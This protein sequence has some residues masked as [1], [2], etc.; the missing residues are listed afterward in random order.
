MEIKIESSWFEGTFSALSDK[1]VVISVVAYGHPKGIPARFCAG[2]I[3]AIDLAKKLSS[4]MVRT[5]IRL[6]DP[7]PIANHCNG[8]KDNDSRF[9]DIVSEFLSANNV[10]FT[11]DGAENVSQ[12]SLAILSELGAELDSASDPEILGLVQRIKESGR[13]HGG[14]MGAKNAVLYMAAHP[15]SWLDLY[16]PLIW[17]RKH[18]PEDTLFANLMSK[19]ESRF[20]IVR[21]FLQT[22]RPDLCSGIDPIE[23]YMTVCNTPCY[24]P[25]DEEPTVDDLTSHGYEWC[26]QRYKALK[27]ASGNHRRAV[28]DFAAIMSFT[29]RV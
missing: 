25:L 8:W 20:T 26:H 13:K 18:V 10:E 22:R 12:D 14:D 16:H 29:G 19:P 11:F 7:T 23:L 6:I 15:F 27:S 1:S 28:K 4:N 3:P 24:I 17:A 2:F 21:K 9:R 5:N